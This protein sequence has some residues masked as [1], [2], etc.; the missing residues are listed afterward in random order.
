MM[1]LFRVV[2]SDHLVFPH[3]HGYHFYQYWLRLRYQL[4][5]VLR[6]VH[7]LAL[8]L[9][10]DSFHRFVKWWHHCFVKLAF[11]YSWEVVS[12]RGVVNAIA[13]ISALQPLVSGAAYRIITLTVIFDS[14]SSSLELLQRFE[15]FYLWVID[16]SEI[17]V[18]PTLLMTL[19]LYELMFYVLL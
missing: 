5:C 2:R 1:D 17:N 7:G 15:F 16:L 14:E 11:L 18:I 9:V 4:H 3:V 6:V 12:L 19:N 13:L 8:I 10:L